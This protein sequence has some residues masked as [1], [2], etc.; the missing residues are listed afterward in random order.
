NRYTL[1]GMLERLGV[2]LHD[3]GVVADR[4]EALEAAF[5]QALGMADVVLSSGGVSVGDADHV[6][7]M[8][9]RLGRTVFWKIA[10]KPGRPFA[11][12]RL[13]ANGHFFGL[14]GNPVAVMVT[15]QQLVR[16]ALMRLMGVTQLP[17]VVR[18]PAR[19]LTPLRKAAGRFEFQ[20]GILSQAADGSW[21][22]AASGEQGSGMLSSMS[23]ANC[24][25]CLPE[26]AGN[27]AA[28]DW[29]TVEPF[30]HGV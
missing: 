18:L 2:E 26:A 9:A 16:P 17:P 8:L 24:F 1:F 12:G 11:Y 21:Q 28:G 3:L 22:V 23:L 10:I 25:I 7:T 4:P 14:P 27:A 30:D 15:F 20:R 29:V 19:T 6:R 13:G 5:A